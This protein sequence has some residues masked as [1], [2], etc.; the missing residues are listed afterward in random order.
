MVDL[1][2]S[3]VISLLKALQVLPVSTAQHFMS[4]FCLIQ[5]N[6]ELTLEQHQV[7]LH[8]STYTWS[9]F[10][11]HCKCSFLMIFSITLFSSGLLYCKNTV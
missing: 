4:F 5:D 3:Y 2:P 11:K 8:G 10:S 6:V 9:F 1:R 7:E